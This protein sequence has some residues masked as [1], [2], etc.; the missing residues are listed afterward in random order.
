MKQL[1]NIIDE[2]REKVEIDTQNG[3]RLVGNFFDSNSN[4]G[5]IM[6]PG[7]TE[8]RSSLYAFAERL[9]QVGFKV[10]AFDLNSQGESTGN[11]DIEQM[12]ESAHYIQGHL[13]T[14]YG[15]KRVG[16]FGNS[17]GAM[18]VG[19]ASS[20]K[21]SDL[22]CLCLTG[23]PCSLD[24][25]VP[26]PLIK[27][28]QYIPQSWVRAAA[29]GFDRIQRD[30]L[31]NDNYRRTCR[32]TFRDKKGYSSPAQFGGLKILSLR[33]M[34]RCALNAPRLVDY[35]SDIHRPTLLIYGGEDTLNGIEGSQLPANIQNMYDSLGTDDKK[36]V[37]VPGA[38]HALNSPPMRM[39]DCLNQDPKYSWIKEEVSE[40]FCKYLI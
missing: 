18:A 22:E 31:K 20:R 15:L 24:L 27:I 37:I 12:Q 6:F 5:V 1:R 9:N 36:L 10:W 32:P 39:G 23:A 17:A 2:N 14:K 38:T 35:A 34:A 26:R 25:V 11:W 19:I 30:L 33:E 40:H 21:N 13:K 7:I 8:N 29:I 28:A 3:A 4:K 16:A